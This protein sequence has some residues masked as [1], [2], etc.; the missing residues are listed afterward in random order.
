MQKYDIKD[1]LLEVLVYKAYSRDW[2]ETRDRWVVIIPILGSSKK[3]DWFLYF[4][5]A[6]VYDGMRIWFM[7]NTFHIWYDFYDYDGPKNSK[8]HI[9]AYLNECEKYIFTP[10]NTPS[11]KSIATAW[12]KPC[13]KNFQSLNK[14]KLM[15]NSVDGETE[16][17]QPQ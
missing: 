2:W 11:K 14:K 16:E 4:E 3:V 9:D 6:K 13:R 17:V 1:I 10:I 8:K 7:N 5:G 12:F 15:G